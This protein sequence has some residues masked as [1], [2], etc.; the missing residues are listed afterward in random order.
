MSERA[1]G[2][3]ALPVVGSLAPPFTLPDLDGHPV[4]L[5]SLHAGQHL[6]LFFMR[7]FT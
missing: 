3:T 5:A 7:E 4:S 2:E 6:V 1:D